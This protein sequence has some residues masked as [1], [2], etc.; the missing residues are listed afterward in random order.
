MSD[1]RQP[2]TRDPNGRAVHSRLAWFVEAL[3]AELAR[4]GVSGRPEKR[5]VSD[6]SARRAWAWR[7]AER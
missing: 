7:A 2:S 1:D 6:S 4:T 3:R 5:Q